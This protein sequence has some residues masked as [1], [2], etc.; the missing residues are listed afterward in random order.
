MKYLLDIIKLI[1]DNPD[2]LK[3]IYNVLNMLPKKVDETRANELVEAFIQETHK[4]NVGL[5]KLDSPEEILRKKELG[6][7]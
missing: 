3:V 2:I 4:Y 6:T 5:R 1:I 7:L